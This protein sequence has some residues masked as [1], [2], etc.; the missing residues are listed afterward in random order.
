MASYEER[1]LAADIAKIR[2]EV[3]SATTSTQLGSSSIN[4][5]GKLLIVDRDGREVMDIGANP[6][7]SFGATPRIG[8]VPPETTAPEVTATPGGLSIRW[9]GEYVDSLMTPDD[10]ARVEVHLSEDPAFTA[11]FAD[12]IVGTMETPRGAD[13]PVT[14]LEVGK[15][16]FVRLVVRN[17]AGGRGPASQTSQG[18]PL[19]GVDGPGAAEALRRSQE[20][21]AAAQKAIED[22]LAATESAQ[23]S[24]IAADG[25]TRVTWDRIPPAPF[26]SSGVTATDVPYRTSPAD[27][28]DKRSRGDVWFEYDGTPQRKVVGQWVFYPELPTGLGV[29]GPG[30]IQQQITDSI[31]SSLTA[32]KITTGTLSA[33]VSITTG[34]PEGTHT[35]IGNSSLTVQR[36]ID[37]ETGPVPTVSI[38]G[39]DSDVIQLANPNTSTTSGFDANGEMWMTNISTDTL[40]LGGKT[41]GLPARDDLL[42][43]FPRGAIA[44]YRPL[45]DSSTAGATPVGVCEISADCEANRLYEAS[46]TGNFS[47][48]AAGTFRLFLFYTTD[49]SNPTISS[50]QLT[51]GVFP[52]TAATHFRASVSAQFVFTGEIRVLLAIQRLTG[53]GTVNYYSDDGS[54]PG[55]FTIT[56]LG[57]CPSAN[58]E[59]WTDGQMNTG[60]GAPVTGGT[61]TP[62]ATKKSYVKEYSA[63]WTRTWRAGAV[64]SDPE[65]RQGNSNGQLM[66]Q[67]GFPAQM[68][69]DL[70]GSV[71]TKVEAFLYASHW[72]YSAGGTALI[73]VHGSASPSNTFAY[74]GSQAGVW[75][76]KTGGKYIMLPTAWNRGW[77]IGTTR[78]FTVGGGAGSSSSYYGRFYGANASS[79]LRPRVRITYTK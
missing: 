1:R 31:I 5:G 79:S 33:G 73:G 38:G 8:P 3:R 48:S 13:V 52:A 66:S 2:R 74:S 45:S 62:S 11:E 50:R 51:M 77:A 28:A 34:D 44:R 72:Y 75:K 76:T 36:V 61:T 16:Y 60:A 15:T 10:F 54:T 63:S 42:F 19:P 68:Q 17:T 32:A 41:V 20:A 56:D 67:I 6:D 69:A 30:W 58:V 21:Q 57:E 78:G 4:N 9:G 70:D 24:L 59:V 29:S 47:N 39:L 46:F 12:T 23:A 49:G 65:V 53:G 7:G 26:V 27:D 43:P 55:T 40:L 64:Q 14:K 18:V 22:A 71:V 37:P 25:K 35:K